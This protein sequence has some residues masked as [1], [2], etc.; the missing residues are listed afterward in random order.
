MISILF[1][2]LVLGVA[3]TK[4]PNG[5]VEGLY[6]SHFPHNP[7]CKPMEKHEQ[8]T[9]IQFDICA[10]YGFQYH[11]LRKVNDSAFAIKSHCSI[12]CT[13]CMVNEIVRVETGK[14]L[15]AHTP[16]G[17]VFAKLRIGKFEFGYNDIVEKLYEENNCVGVNGV[18]IIYHSPYCQPNIFQ[19]TSM[20]MYC[21]DGQLY[22]KT[23][24][25]PHRME[26][27]EG[28]HGDEKPIPI[29]YC[30]GKIGPKE[31]YTMKFYC[32]KPI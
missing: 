30:Y 15:E 13:D 29:D 11:F 21:R 7:T 18:N 9:W 22:T 5:D 1:V 31:A 6:I 27:C 12:G 19:Q 26:V 10:R 17:K 24:T 3:W 4:N 20:E 2:A 25:E 23:Y 28:D 32:G 8:T 14:C 16:M